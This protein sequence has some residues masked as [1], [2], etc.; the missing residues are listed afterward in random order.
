MARGRLGSACAIAAA[1]VLTTTALTAGATRRRDGHA[2]PGAADAGNGVRPPSH[3]LR[4]RSPAGGSAS[5]SFRVDTSA[6]RRAISPLIYGINGDLTV[7][8]RAFT[9]EL[10]A[11]RATLVRLGGDRWS[12]YNWEDNYSNAG[13]DYRYENDDYLSASTRPGAAVLPTVEAAK[14]A[15]ATAL[16]TIPIAGL[17]AAD[18]GGPVALDNP[19][20]AKRFLHDEPTDPAPLS[21]T[22]NLRASAVYQNQFVYWLKHS[23]SGEPVMFSLDN[24]PDL[25]SSTHQEIH[26]EPT[27]YTEL[28]HKDLDYA[29]AIKKIWPS[30]PVTGPVSYGWEGYLTL[31]NAPDSVKLG[32]FLEWWM[33]Q[34]RRADEKAHMVLINDLDLH[35]YPEATGDGVRITGPQDS[36]AVAAAREQAPR[37]LWD[38]GYVEDSWITADSL[39]GHGIDLIPRLESEVAADDPGLRLDFSEWDYGGGDDVSGA[40]AT[41]DVLGIFGKYG[42]H[43]A[44]FWSLQGNEDFAYGAF[45]VYRDY[46]GH[47]GSFGGTEVSAT[48]SDPDGSS[49]YASIG[50]D[51]PGHVVIVVINKHDTALPASLLVTTGGDTTAA[52]FATARVYA[53]TA[54]SPRPRPA[55]SLHAAS[56]GRFDWELPA[57]SVEV[58]VPARGRS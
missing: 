45:A 12:A 36:P 41:A 33:R 34:V 30:A 55:R 2:A 15:G 53:L 39:D 25:W 37:S 51:E 17:V 22:P 54:A 52:D 20:D 48:T 9:A 58:V 11:T 6:G 28:L 4:R 21:M 31:Q 3:A 13:S 44:A 10:A 27:T 5:V 7:D 50:A 56:N 46:D 23:V 26:P 16:V 29:T 1:V 19:P 14:A 42:V 40:I 24:E 8:G 57:Q 43:A 35:W 32:N 47:G 18:A 38:P 49:V